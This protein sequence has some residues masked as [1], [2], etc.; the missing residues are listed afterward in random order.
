VILSIL[1]GILFNR[2]GLQTL[3]ASWP[4]TESILGALG[5][6]AGLTTPLVALVIGFEM[7]LVRGSLLKPF[8]VV[9]F[10]LLFWVPVGLLLST[11]VVGRWLKLDPVYQAAVMTMVILPPP[12]V[13][14]L[15]MSDAS[16]EDQTFVANSLSIATLA[17]L[18]AFAIVSLVFS[19]G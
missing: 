10:R 18:F 7:Q 12:F 14:P 9:G 5:L 16:E 8:A 15:F 13:I 2:L 1:F 6:V 11:L 19:P 3:M 17:T 4:V